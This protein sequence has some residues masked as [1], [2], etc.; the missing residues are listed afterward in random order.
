MEKKDA[1][2]SEKTAASRWV[3]VE[4]VG[5]IDKPF[6][7]LGFAAVA[8]PEGNECTGCSWSILPEESMMHLESLIFSDSLRAAQAE[9]NDYG[10]FLFKKGSGQGATDSLVLGRA[11]S[12]VV[13][14]EMLPLVDE[15]SAKQISTVLLRLE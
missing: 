12:V 4:H 3:I 13:F 15:A 9:G 2:S 7:S 10:T 5:V 8:V 1:T 6:Q 14:K 11:K